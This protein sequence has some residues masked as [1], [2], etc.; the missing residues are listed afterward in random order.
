[1][2]RFYI[3]DGARSGLRCPTD[4]FRTKTGRQSDVLNEAQAIM[5]GRKLVPTEAPAVVLSRLGPILT[6]TDFNLVD[7]ANDRSNAWKV[8]SDAAYSDA[9]NGA[10]HTG[11]YWYPNVLVGIGAPTQI[12][13]DLGAQHSIHSYDASA[14]AMRWYLEGS[15]TGMAGPW[16]MIDNQHPLESGVL[17]FRVDIFGGARRRTLPAPSAP[18][19]Y[20]RFSVTSVG[21]YDGTQPSWGLSMAR[22]HL[23]GV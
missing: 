19:R 5:R 4:E 21:Q 18:F 10:N 16:T 13:V 15:N 3:S 14:N 20:I 8:F 22:M 6:D 1:M 23:Y 2:S 7:S 17:N 12:W 9:G 11:N